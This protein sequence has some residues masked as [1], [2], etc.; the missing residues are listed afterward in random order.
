MSPQKFQSVIH[1][2][3]K[4]YALVDEHYKNR[5]KC[6]PQECVAEN[7]AHTRHR[8]QQ[9]AQHRDSGHRSTPPINL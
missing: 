8:C 5:N 9:Q 7:D 3:R 4:P 2:I 6:V 1:I